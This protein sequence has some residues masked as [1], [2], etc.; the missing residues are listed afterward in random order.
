MVWSCL[1]TDEVNIMDRHLFEKCADAVLQGKWRLYL[2]ITKL[3][4][5]RANEW[6]SSLN[7]VLACSVSMTI[8]VF[9][10]YGYIH[11]IVWQ[12][13]LTPLEPRRPV[14]TVEVNFAQSI[15]TW[16]AVCFERSVDGGDLAVMGP[17]GSRALLL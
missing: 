10:K 5:V 11:A 12:N 4:V 3:M 7:L 15:T 13:T 16:P 17:C 14:K 2:V 6:F 9:A 1:K 8:Y